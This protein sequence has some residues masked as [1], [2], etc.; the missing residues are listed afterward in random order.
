MNTN[1]ET[2]MNSEDKLK[3]MYGQQNP[4]GVPENYFDRFAENMLESLPEKD[5]SPKMVET[6]E[7]VEKT[8]NTRRTLFVKLK[9]YLYLA[10]MFCGLYFGIQVMKHRNDIASVSKIEQTAKTD[11]FEN[12]DEYIDKVCRYARIGKDDIYSY[13]T[14]QDYAY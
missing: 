6:S 2:I 1:K 5:E 3:K 4:F 9:P 7:V 8:D 13:A 11:A 14:G 10:A 12:E